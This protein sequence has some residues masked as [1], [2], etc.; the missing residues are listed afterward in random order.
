MRKNCPWCNALVSYGQLWSR[1]EELVCPHCS[2]PLRLNRESRLWAL[3]AVPF[4]LAIACTLAIPGLPTP[5]M[6]VLVGLA[7]IATIGV[8]LV[9]LNRPGFSGELIT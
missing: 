8:V 3:L 9:E 5:T 7:S 4:L 1:P 6:P 2:K